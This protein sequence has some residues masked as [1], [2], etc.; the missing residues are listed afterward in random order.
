MC[1]LVKAKTGNSP[2]AAQ[3]TGNTQ[4]G[5]AAS[6]ADAAVSEVSLNTAAYTAADHVTVAEPSSEQAAPVQPDAAAAQAASEQAPT[7]TAAAPSLEEGSEAWAAALA[8]AAANSSFAPAMRPVA[9]AANTQKVCVCVVFSL[10]A[11]LSSDACLHI[12]TQNV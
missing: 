1:A 4:G 5:N 9:V 3:A 6:S 10:L 8:A 12:C 7:Q 2:A 11:L